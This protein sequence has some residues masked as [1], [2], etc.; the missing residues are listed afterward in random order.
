M[1]RKRTWTTI[2]TNEH[3][4]I[5]PADRKEM[6]LERELQIFRKQ[7]AL[8]DYRDNDATTPELLLKYW[9][10]FI[11]W[12]KRAKGER[13]FFEKILSKHSCLRVFDASMGTGFDSIQLMRNGFDV[14]SNE[15]DQRYIEKALE[16]ARRWRRLELKITSYDWREIPEELHGSY[17]AVIC[18]GNSLSLLR[19]KD[20]QKKSIENF[21]NLVKPGG[22]VII[23]QR[24]YDYIL[25]KQKE[26][27]QN[28]INFIYSRD[29]Y[30]CSNR[31]VGYPIAMIDGLVAFEYKHLGINEKLCRLF[32]YPFRDNELSSLMEESGLQVETYY[33]F[34]AREKIGIV[35]ADVW[36]NIDFYQHVGIKI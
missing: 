5:S 14:T 36:G 20:D 26:I 35:G 29:Y 8:S 13:R 19:S 22:L 1:E 16:N 27:F 18:L 34:K 33:D 25:R 9:D 2:T 17:D 3:T 7:E 10:S 4:W 30:Y 6:A 12:K 21:V 32:L 24:N 31:I 15:I 23:D 28:P 11:D